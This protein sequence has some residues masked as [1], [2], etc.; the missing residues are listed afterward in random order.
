MEKKKANDWM[1]QSQK[2]PINDC[3]KKRPQTKDRRYCIGISNKTFYTHS[4][5]SQPQ[6]K[7]N[8]NT[9][10]TCDWPPSHYWP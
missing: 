5:S 7:A 2:T 4:P 9:I 6:S 8:L 3:Q 1:S 10:I